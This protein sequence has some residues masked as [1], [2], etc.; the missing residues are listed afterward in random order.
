VTLAR[1]V[2]S[3]E[4]R[5]ML[6]VKGKVGVVAVAFVFAAALSGSSHAVW[7]VVSHL[8]PTSRHTCV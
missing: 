5:T 6:D 1:E 7:C 3:V 2:G 4:G 8:T